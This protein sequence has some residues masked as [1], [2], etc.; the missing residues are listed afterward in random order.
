MNDFTS[1]KP[2]L[3]EPLS[4]SAIGSFAH[5]TITE[6]FPKIVR[7]T[8]ADNDFPEEI[9]RNLEQLISD[10]PF[11]PIRDLQDAGAPDLAAW[12]MNLQPF[13]GKNWLEVPWFVAEMYFYRRILEATGFH[14]PGDFQGFD[15]FRLQKK[16]VLE[17][18]D[19]STINLAELLERSLQNRQTGSTGW[20]AHLRELLVLN[21]WGNQA[22]LSMWSSNEERPDHKA[23]DDQQ[24]H[25]L[26]EDSSLVAKFFNTGSDRIQQVDFILDNYG[27]ELI[28]DIGLADY[29]L[30]INLTQTV[31]FHAKPT[32]H[33]VSD[34]MIPDVL[35]TQAYLEGHREAAVRNLGHRIA[36]YLQEGQLEIT[37]D[38]FW[39][40]PTYFWDM[41]T[42]IRDLLSSADLV[43]SKGDANYRRLA[44][45]LDWS[46]T[47]SFEYVMRYFPTALLALRVLKAE[48]A[49]GLSLSQVERLD[50]DDPQWKV[51]GNWAVI[52]FSGQEKQV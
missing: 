10:I 42:Y 23:S 31:R 45:D 20:Q 27:P 32:P 1:P 19:S 51:N 48:L 5:T 6:R 4:G 46:P 30:A 25:L 36:G 28:H 37:Q 8:I 39:T 33:Y 47:T 40:S 52:Q 21:V 2:P 17:S 7:E 11:E 16:R 12:K 18:A 9:L 14:Q 50:F 43:V 35:S 24:S 34:A 3:P 22:D 38:H 13:T 41:P 44:G 49:L 26:V 29:L 15:P